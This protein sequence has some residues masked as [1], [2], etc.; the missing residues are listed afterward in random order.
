ML[1]A[2]ESAGVTFV[3]GILFCWL[4]ERWGNLWPAIV[5]HA[6]LDLVWMSFQLGDNAAGDLVANVARLAALA[7]AI[8]GALFF[9]SS[10]LTLLPDMWGIR[11]FPRSDFRSDSRTGAARDKK[12]RHT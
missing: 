11:I 12:R 8:A 6:G 5:I 4:T 2:L 9:T 10:Q 1:T 3:G 7:V